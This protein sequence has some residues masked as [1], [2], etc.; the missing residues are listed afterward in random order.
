[1]GGS[2]GDLWG[3]GRSSIFRIRAQEMFSN[4]RETALGAKQSF[5]TLESG[6]G[7]LLKA[8]ESV[9]MIPVFSH[10]DKR[11]IVEN[12]NAIFQLKM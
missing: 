1:M 7:S 9:K 5:S 4:L 12:T 8:L 3:Q 11:R 10:S 2:E 6:V